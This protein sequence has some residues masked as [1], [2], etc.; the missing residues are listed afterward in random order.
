MKKIVSILFCT[1]LLFGD[2]ALSVQ[3]AELFDLKRQKLKKDTEKLKNS[4]ISPLSINSSW[5][6]NVNAGNFDGTS[7]K[8][9][10]GLRQDIFRSG[11]IWYAVD[12]AK[13]YGEAQKLGIDI[14]EASQLKA[15]Y[16]L[17]VKIRREEL[18]LKQSELLLKNRM[19][20]VDI[21]KESYRAGNADISRLNR[22]IIDSDNARNTLIDAKSMLRNEKM[23]LRKLTDL[24]VTDK[25][26]IPD[27]PLVDKDFYLSRHL[28]LLRYDK[29][30]KAAKAQYKAV[31]SNYFP[32]VTVNANYG[33]SKFEGDFQN[34]DGDEYG[35]GIGLFI[36]IDINTKNDIESN[37]LAYL[38]TKLAAIDRKKELEI[39]YDKRVF[40]I[41]DYE[42]KMQ[43]SRQMLKM[44]DELYN[45]TLSQVKAGLKTKA[46]KDSLLNSIKIQKLE[47]EIQQKNIELEKMA[48][49]FDLKRD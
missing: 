10:L 44:Y 12:Y 36:P 28:E 41:K 18:R 23:E 5:Q 49:F 4:W 13:A 32:K 33:Y 14:S 21:V 34:Y 8:A 26:E 42:R 40:N 48:L 15:L 1:T 30:T 31:R 38:Q 39:E 45:F 16:T 11:G 37:K 43:V 29:E 22:V 17:A 47:Y 27:I 2:I 9:S 25:L 19:I 24:N 3:K 35:Y 46:E 20:D 7:T 6:R